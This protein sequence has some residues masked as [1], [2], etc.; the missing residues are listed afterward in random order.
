ML[1]VKFLG[2]GAAEGIPAINCNCPHC[3]RAR[4]ERGKLIRQRS[5]LLVSLPDYELLVET[6]PDIRALLDEYKITHID[7]IFLSHAHYDHAS[8][9]WEFLYWPG[10]IDLFIEGSVYKALRHQ[11]GGDRLSDITF[12]CPCRPGV[13]IRF[14]SFFFTPFAVSH[15]V[16][17]FG[18]AFYE[19]GHKVIYAADT[20]RRFSNYARSL[21][22]KADLLIIN[23]PRFEPP[24][25]DHLTIVE[26]VALKE[27]LAV[28][29]LILTHINHHNRPHD[30]LEAYVSQ[31]AGVSVAYDG[32]TV[33]LP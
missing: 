12:Y 3:T 14:D 8:G 13:A 15:T 18:L 24:H 4:N 7:G 16:P 9:L 5:A 33:S 23:V 21:I 6:P 1:Q 30:E 22:S 19:G 27:E 2:T 31:F 10:D 32:L 11:E 17:C 28:R 25:E 20:G 29:H 26:A